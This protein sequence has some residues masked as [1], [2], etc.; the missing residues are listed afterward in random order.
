MKTE[1]KD[2]YFKTRENDITM[3]YQNPDNKETYFINLIGM[4]LL[5]VETPIKEVVEIFNKHK[6]SLEYEDLCPSC[7]NLI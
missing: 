1:I 7:G 5:P 4:V 2:C 3:F 6:L